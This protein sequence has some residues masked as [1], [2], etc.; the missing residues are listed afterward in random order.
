MILAAENNVAA[1]PHSAP[2]SGATL[3][4]CVADGGIGIGRHRYPHPYTHPGN[5]EEVMQEVEERLLA[6][7]HIPEEWWIL[8]PPTCPHYRDG[9]EPCH[10]PCPASCPADYDGS[11]CLNPRCSGNSAD[12]GNEDCTQFHV[13][14]DLHVAEAGVEA[15]GGARVFGGCECNSL[16]A[17]PATAAAAEGS[18]VSRPPHKVPLENLP[19]VVDN[20][21]EREECMNGEVRV[22]GMEGGEVPAGGGRGSRDEQRMNGGPKRKRRTIYV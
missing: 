22:E 19:D 10:A 8:A 2:G 16:G 5:C 20:C 18:N 1:K 4:N 17:S 6:S 3:A 15:A 14:V 7:P 13:D 12:T 11:V 9:P 21:S